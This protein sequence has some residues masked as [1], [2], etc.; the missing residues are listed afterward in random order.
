M[1]RILCPVDFSE[2]SRAAFDRAV[3]VARIESAAV[4]V[5][6]VYPSPTSTGA[7]PFGPE[8]P[9]PY[10]LRQVDRGEATAH[11]REFL[12]G[13]DTPDVPVD[14]HVAEASAVH[15]EILEQAARQGADLIVIG[16]HGRSGFDRL[17]L[18]SVAEK[19]LRSARVP[20][21]TVPPGAQ[22]PGAQGHAPFSRLL[23]AVDFSDTSTAALD[24]AV[25]LARASGGRV[26]VLHVVELLPIAYEP[27]VTPPFDAAQYRAALEAAALAQLQ[28]LVPASLRDV[29]QTRVVSSARAYEGILNA[30]DERKAEL[31]AIGV[32]GRNMLDRLLFGSTA[33]RV[34]RRARCPVL[35]VRHPAPA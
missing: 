5:L 8:G 31:I 26:T 1:R 24:A 6:Y 33:E 21:L 2:F 27:M 19:V 34:V 22:E 16:T 12:G 13:T 4:T 20:V 7:V 35:T 9:G 14:L 17:L 15:R 32:H 18:G 30:A 25:S 23:C 10:G 28:A 11:L 3:A 29:C